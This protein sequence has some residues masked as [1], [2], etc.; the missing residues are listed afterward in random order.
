MVSGSV[1]TPAMEEVIRVREIR[2]SMEQSGHF[3]T[4]ICSPI[5]GA[6]TN[7]TTPKNHLQY[8]SSPPRNYDLYMTLDVTPEEE[9]IRRKKSSGGGVVS[10]PSKRVL[11]NRT[12]ESIVLDDTA[13]SS[14]NSS[15]T[16]HE[17]SVTVTPN[18]NEKRT[19]YKRKLEI[20]L[21]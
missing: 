7:G 4:P 1:L 21:C 6:F 3:F 16:G 11:R 5:T 12:H 2:K 8:P 10:S 19:V 17:L 14:L 13:S 15:S 20:K 9:P 18:K